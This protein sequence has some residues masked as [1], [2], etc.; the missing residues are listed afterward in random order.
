MLTPTPEPVIVSRGALVTCNIMFRINCI[1]HERCY[2]PEI[3]YTAT[4]DLKCRGQHIHRACS[5]WHARRREVEAQQRQLH[6]R[7]S[8]RTRSCPMLRHTSSQPSEGIGHALAMHWPCTR[9]QP[10][11]RTG[12]VDCGC[13]E[14]VWSRQVCGLALACCPAF[15]LA[16]SIMIVRQCYKPSEWHALVCNSA[17]T[18]A[19]LKHHRCSSLPTSEGSHPHITHPATPLKTA[20]L[21]C[22]NVVA[23]IQVPGGVA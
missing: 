22:C 7:I 10:C 23:C 1:H 19:T 18:L 17:Y 6:L 3:E 9:M 4:A 2:P 12:H 15:A 8:T 20:P 5:C 13:E 11:S 16:T 14:T 21:P